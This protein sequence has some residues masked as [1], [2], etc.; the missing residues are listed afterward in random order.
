MGNLWCARQIHWFSSL[1][2][3][4]IISSRCF[5]PFTLLVL[6]YSLVTALTYYSVL[7][8]NLSK[9]IES[10]AFLMHF[11]RQLIIFRK[12]LASN[13]V[14]YSKFHAI[15]IWYFF[16]KTVNINA[17]IA[18]T[19][20]LHWTILIYLSNKAIFLKHNKVFFSYSLIHQKSV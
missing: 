12:N 18:R 16:S 13:S 1:K 17:E 5:G 2:S 8:N 11:W 14:F 19:I 3:F 7:N 20:E 6:L 9:N 15:T 10:L 4:Q